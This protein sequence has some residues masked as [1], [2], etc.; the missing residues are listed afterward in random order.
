MAGNP[1]RGE[2]IRLGSRGSPLALAQ[3]EE[4]RRRLI[5]AAPELAEPGALEIVVVRTTGDRVQDRPLAEIGGKGLFT[6]ELEEALFDDRIDIAVHSMKDVPTWQP[7]GLAVV[8]V[9]P[10]EDPRDAFFSPHGGRL[11]ALPSGA[12]VGTAS[13]RRQAQV[14]LARPDLR[15]APIRGNVQTRLG[16]LAAGD[17]D[18]TLLAVAG[19]NRLGRADLL[20]AVLPVAEMLPA[21]AQGAI[22][23]QVRFDDART[24]ELARRLDDGPSALRVAAERACLEVLDGSCRTPIAVLAELSPDGL[25]LN[26]SALV[27]RPDGTEAWRAT[28]E[29]PAAE[30]A[31]LGREAGEELRRAAGPAFFAELVLPAWDGPLPGDGD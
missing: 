15:V 3:A 21:A 24:H 17:Y 28:R 16:K 31:A 27:A 1:Q 18:A 12:L 7:A 2:A 5:A 26:L 9:L 25:R 13:L 23:L 10:R 8:A 30:A 29:G 14:L 22:G 11:S 19:L 20:Q 6:K 4:A